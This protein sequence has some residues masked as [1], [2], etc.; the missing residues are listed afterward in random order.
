V[1]FSCVG[2]KFSYP[3]PPPFPPTIHTLMGANGITQGTTTCFMIAFGE[4]FLEYS[5]N[6]FEKVFEFF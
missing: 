1:F 3:P 2:L 5:W 6:I 4:I